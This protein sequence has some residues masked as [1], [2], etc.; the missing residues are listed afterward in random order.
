MALPGMPIAALLVLLFGV[1]VLSS[2]ASGS[3][4]ALARST[5]SDNAYVPARSLLRIAS[6]TAQIGGNACGGL[7]VLAVAPRGALLVN[8]A[9][10]VFS[11]ATVRFRLSDYP[12]AGDREGNLIR[13]SL[14]GLRDVFGFTDLR[15]LLVFGWLAPMCA[16]AP[17]ALAA[18]YV[19]AHHGSAALVG[20]WLIALPVGLIVGDVAGVR[21]LRPELQRRLVAPLATAAFVPYLAFAFDPPIRLALPL[22]VFSGACGLYSLGLDARVRDAAPPTLFA[23]AM[24]LN[25]AGLMTLQGLGFAVAGA[26][27]QGIGSAPTI[28]VAG[29]AGLVATTWLL[30]S[31]YRTLVIPAGTN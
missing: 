10:Y 13:N 17:E 26:L 25:T 14:S 22:L 16:V 23:R 2:V 24:T 20:W 11:A 27:A 8:A 28:A 19:A 9:S 30:R 4:A 31:D 3:R 21:W 29:A 12:N 5:V 7:L 1:G 15:R 6:Q 18:P